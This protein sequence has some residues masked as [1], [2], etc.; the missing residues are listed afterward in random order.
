MPGSGKR[1][2]SFQEYRSKTRPRKFIKSK[3]KAPWIYTHIWLSR[4]YWKTCQTILFRLEFFKVAYINLPL[5]TL[6][7]QHRISKWLLIATRRTRLTAAVGETRIR[8]MRSTRSPRPWIMSRS[9][10]MT[11]KWFCSRISS[12][13]SRPIRSTRFADIQTFIREIL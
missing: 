4:K 6:M 13:A 5:R 12:F 11:P 8:V 2:R 10:K 9:T 7:R 1:G 3:L